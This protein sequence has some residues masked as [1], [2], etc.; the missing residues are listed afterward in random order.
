MFGLPWL[1]ACSPKEEVPL[2]MD[3]VNRYVSFPGIIHPKHYNKYRDRANGHH[4]IVWTGGGNA[5]KA[6]ITTPV[7][8]EQILDALLIIGAIPGD[9]LTAETWT[10]R[11]DPSSVEPDQRVEGTKID[12]YVQWEEEELS[13]DQIFL[14]SE[15]KDFEFR[16][17]GHRDLISVWN[18][19]CVT[20]L[21]SCPGGRTSNANYTIRD[22]AQDRKRFVADVSKLPKDGTSVL[23]RFEIEQKES[24][25][26]FQVE[27]SGDSD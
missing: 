23:V 20:C 22:Q 6:L 25:P 7:S 21:F 2:R 13:A 14:E 26:Q 8:D 4:F 12:I 18:S 16:V 3:L 1:L 27:S 5:K 17:G 9:N 24:Q 11:D 10:K 15:K 19:G